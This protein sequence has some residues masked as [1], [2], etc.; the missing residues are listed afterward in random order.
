LETP[1]S[2]AISTF[3]PVFRPLWVTNFES[4][5]V[6][7]HGLRISEALS[8]TRSSIKRGY[9]RVVAKKK[10]KPSDE[11][12]AADTLELW[13]RVAANKL[14]NTLVFGVSRQWCSEIFHRCAAKARIELQPRQGIHSLRH[15]IAH[16]L[17]DSGAPLPVVQKALRHRSIGSTSVYIEAD[18]ADVDRWRGQAI[19]G[20]SVRNEALAQAQALAGVG[21]T[22]ETREAA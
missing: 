11:K 4:T 21:A 1:P 17:L 20:A 13:N 7:Q 18:S 3:K 22:T 19:A 5:F 12:M 2:G 14:P 8:L 16:H 10:G 6:Y 9:L 15:S